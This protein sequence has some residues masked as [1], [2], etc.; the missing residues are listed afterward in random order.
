MSDMWR[1]L[2]LLRGEWRWG[3]AGVGLSAVVSL[4]NTALL[5]LSGWFI[6][7]MALAG[8]GGPMIEYFT[9]AAAI[10][11]LAILRTVGRYLER[12]VTHDATFRLLT[13]LRVWF[14]T[15][16]EPLAPA[17]LQQ[18]RSG[19][20]LSR[21]RADIDSLETFYLRVFVP[22]AAA[23]IATPLMGA[24]L[25]WI[26]PRVAGVDM[27]GLA[28]AGVAVPLL[29]QRLGHRPGGEAVAL[30]G[31]LTA[32]IADLTRGFAELTVD[33]A[34]ASQMARC[35]E[36]GVAQLGAQRRL[37]GIGA[38]GSVLG[39][40]VAQLS[41]WLVLL[42]TLP[43]ADGERLS[44]PD[45]AM[46]G[47]LVLASFEITAP[48]PAAFKALGEI[49]AAARR[50]FEIA[51]AV[52]ATRDP[53][54]PEAAPRRFDVRVDGLTLRYGEGQP[55][56]LEHL[57]FHVPQGGC[58]GIVGPSGAGKTSLLNVLLRFLEFQSGAVEIGGV[59]LGA[60]EGE[61]VRGL[62]AVVA[63]RTHLFN[64]S[65]RE[66]LL[67]ARPNATDAE[68]HEALRQAALLNEVRAMP[69][70]LE[71]IVGEGGRNLSGGQARR[72]AI[73]RAVLKDAPILLLDEPTEGLDAHSEQ[74][75]LEALTR[76]MRHRTTLLVTHRPQALRL[77]DKVLNLGVCYGTSPP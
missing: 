13:R 55:N 29:A 19:D 40:L 64:T 1:L 11:G 9:P 14:Y 65:I 48:L 24:F 7:A 12:L 77:A 54:R 72:I 10:R 32:D 17:R 31:R 36:T 6:A 30:R 41:L 35:E 46:L 28:L 68:L 56:V 75:V 69:E 60:L 62:C 52:P 34:L 57:S 58:L 16:L 50:I 53:A 73:A 38:A 59:P 45:I 33:Q 42:L 63:Q 20:L 43:L 51:D 22:G 18:Y 5:G 8:H 2:K 66:N 71:T 61:T 67:V 49:M 39:G 47:L 21:I 37:A 25:A 70:G 76:L 15:R 26:S 27:V 23:L 4:A 74:A 44:G 3:L